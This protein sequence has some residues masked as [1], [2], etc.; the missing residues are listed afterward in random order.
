M[1][2]YL[3]KGNLKVSIEMDACYA[4]LTKIEREQQLVNANKINQNFWAENKR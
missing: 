1:F 2:E 3:L 4:P